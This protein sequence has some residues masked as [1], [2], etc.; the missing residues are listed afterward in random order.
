MTAASNNAGEVLDRLIAVPVEQR[1]QLLGEFGDAAVA[2]AS[3]IEHA[4][5]M[6]LT[7]AS[8]ADATTDVLVNLADRVGSQLDRARARRARGRTLSYS[9]RFQDALAVCREGQRLAEEAGDAIETGR[10][11]LA[12]MHALGELGRLDEAIKAG[13]AAREAF[14][15]AGERS[16]AARADLNIGTALQRGDAPADAIRHF[17]RARPLLLNEPLILAPL[18][19]NRGEALFALNEFEAARRAFVAALANFRLGQSQAGAAIAE[20]NLADVATRQGRLQ[21]AIFHFEHARRSLEGGASPAHLARLIAEQAEVMSALGLVAESIAEFERSLAQLDGLGLVLEAARARTGLGTALLRLGR[22]AQAETALA[23]AATAYAELKHETARARV[24]LLRAELAAINGRT[25][26][27]R[28]IALRA[29]ATLH[30]RPADAIAARVV[31]ARI[32]SAEGRVEESL[33]E[34]DIGLTMARQLDIAPLLADL[35][36]QRAMLHRR[37]NRIAEA[38]DDLRQAVVEV[39]RIRGAL[40]GD[41][42]RTAFLGA[43]SSAYESLIAALL[44]RDEPGDA[45]EAFHAAERSRSRSLLDLLQRDLSTSDA[46]DGELDSNAD[47]LAQL[48]QARADLNALY[49]VL[50][51]SRR[52]SNHSPNAL[53]QWRERVRRCE[54]TVDEI[55]SRLAAA[56]DAPGAGA[57]FTDSITIE[58]ARALVPVRGAIIEYCAIDDEILAFVVEPDRLTTLRRL[59]SAGEVAR[60]LQAWQFQVGRALRPGALDGARCSRLVGDA[61]AVLADLAAALLAPMS[62]VL[63]RTRSLIIAPHG[64]LHMLPMHALVL[65]SRHLIETHN[66]SYAASLS[67][68]ERLREPDSSQRRSPGPLVV[69]VADAQAPHIADEAHEVARL[70]NCDQRQ[71]LLDSSA[72]VENFLRA[73]PSATLLHLACHGRYAPEAPMGSG[74]R[75]ADRWLT[76][77]DLMRLQLTADLVMLSGCETAVNLVKAGDELQGLF[78]GFFAAGVP[79]VLASLWRVDDLTTREFVAGFYGCLNTLGPAA[80]SVASALQQAQRTLL[81]RHPHPAMWA[82]FVLAGRP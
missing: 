70:L 45:A 25:K 47:L 37:G 9:G 43:R 4:G 10:A 7:S 60:M 3:L 78:R 76:V 50:N 8:N 26:D 23:A 57:F 1:A 36:V 13:E 2:L 64:I 67:L 82:P 34:L 81:E 17:D 59:A 20:S 27:A 29:L 40:Q 53:T 66:V 54:Q 30:D 38:I 35:H 14:L 6:A 16:L 58:R 24:D 75:L 52:A 48:Q 31:L 80:G 5:R 51:D 49:S 68:L 19:N 22:N 21:A 77:R 28:A 72:T 44:D 18:E 32:A 12:S 61:R 39:E 42:I 71:V 41:R 79:R 65:N 69:G 74:L 33:A 62:E 63:D 46:E 15:A 73:A 55:E 11:Q 56:R